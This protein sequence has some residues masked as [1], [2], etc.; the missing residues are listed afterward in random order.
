MAMVAFVLLIA[1]ANIAGLML[2]RASTRAKE[3]AIRTALGA[4]RGRLIRQ[5]LTES[6]LVSALGAGLGL[7]VARWGA[8]LL[9]RELATARNPIFVDLSL[10]WR[11]LGFTGAVAIL[12]GSVIGLMP[13][14][15]S[16]G[17]SLMTAM[18][19]TQSAGI[20]RRL[21]AGRWIVAGQVALSLVLL[22]GGG[23]LLRTFVTLLTLDMGF[24]RSNVLVVIAKAPWFAADIVKMAPEQ[25][26]AAY[27][28][29]ASRVRALPGVLSAARAFTTPLGDDNWFTDISVDAP[30]APSGEQATV[31]FNFVT[32]GY[33]AHC[34]RIGSGVRRRLAA[35]E[36]AFRCAAARHGND[37][38]R[39]VPPVRDGTG[40]GLSAGAP[41]DASGSD[42]R[43]S[44]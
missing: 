17:M 15:R 28:E 26:S 4:S 33:F 11:M 44:V 40:R 18:K 2:A 1:C 23:L 12:T 35:P 43:A 8:A 10:D 13:A 9:V 29:I 30:G 31:W 37:G 6:V 21:H 41:S 3:I 32:P 27:D 38:Y 19:S 20:E 39:S 16:T 42:D 24:D 7:L 36:N 25:R 5:M 14:V 22:I 34:C